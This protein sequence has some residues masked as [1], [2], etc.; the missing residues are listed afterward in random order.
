MVGK[1]C[2]PGKAV[3]P[4]FEPFKLALLKRLVERAKAAKIKIVFVTAPLL[5][6]CGSDWRPLFARFAKLAAE[7]GVPYRSFATA[8]RDP[9]DFFDTNHIN[10][11]AALRYSALVAGFVDEALKKTR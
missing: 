3:D 7:W 5:I 11:R 1:P 6:D 2:R 10:R 8:M 4:P 9:A